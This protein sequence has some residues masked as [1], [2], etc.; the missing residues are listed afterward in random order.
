MT[1]PLGDGGT[2]CL[3]TTLD[4]NNCGGCAQSC[5]A[6]GIC[7]DGACSCPGFFTQCAT[8]SSVYCTHTTV[9]RNNCGACGHICLKC[10]SCEIGQCTA[11]NFFTSSVTVPNIPTLFNGPI[12]ADLNLDGY[13]D[14]AINGYGPSSLIAILN[15][16]DGGFQPPTTIYPIGDSMTSYGTGIVAGDFNG[17]GLPDLAVGLIQSDFSTKAAVYFGLGDAGFYLPDGGLWVA[18]PFPISA[19]SYYDNIWGLVAGDFNGDGRQDFV[20]LGEETGLTVFYQV[21]GGFMQSP[22]ETGVDAGYYFRGTLATGDLN[23]DGRTDLI[24]GFSLGTPSVVA[25]IAV[26]GGFVSVP[27]SVPASSNYEGP[28]MAVSSDGLLHVVADELR[29]FRYAA[30]AGFVEV[31]EYPLPDHFA[32]YGYAPAATA[33]DLNGDG[34][35]DLVASSYSGVAVWLRNDGGYDYPFGVPI[36]H[37]YIGMAV[38]A[39]NG[40]SLPDFIFANYSDATV[41]KNNSDKCSP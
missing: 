38:G 6:D 36:S 1:C 3:D 34:Q 4:P 30:D 7:R 14:L 24:V 41:L 26:S 28:A 39:V 17:D 32:P 35:S 5:G 20:V 11:Q 2:T 21:A 27:V 15:G 19:S 40:D 31:G 12:L 13:P 16:G 9:D 10:E 37:Y 23:A 33:T 18:G 22:I 25:L 29:T 8:A